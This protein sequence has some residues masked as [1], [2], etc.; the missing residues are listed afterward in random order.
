MIRELQQQRARRTFVYES[1]ISASLRYL[2]T[3]FNRLA[4]QVELV[5]LKTLI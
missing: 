2:E 4:I 5:M 1:D 3:S